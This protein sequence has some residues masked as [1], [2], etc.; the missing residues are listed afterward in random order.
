MSTAPLSIPS[1]DLVCER[2]LRLPC[3]P[4]LLPRLISV[5]V[6]PDS[7]AD[8]VADLIKVDAALAASTLRLA[9]SAFFSANGKADSVTDAVI[10]LGSREL[11]RLAALALVGR[12]ETGAGGRGEPG[13]FC[14][15]ALCTALAAEVLA[16]TSERID[17]QAAYTAGLVC[18]LG[19]L[20]LAH[21]CAPCFPAIRSHCSAHGG[22]WSDAEQAVLGYTH[23]EV[24]ARLLKAWNFPEPLIAAAEFCE[25]PTKAPAE[26]LA[27]LAHLHAAKY[28]ATSFGPGVTE[29]G[30][31]FEL[32]TDFL[33]EWG[34]TP[35]L[36]QESMSIVHERART[37][38]QEKLTHGALVL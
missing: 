22:S 34:F 24:G 8:E 17:P 38:L 15:H 6:A 28:V 29:D 19:K 10:R 16:E 26:S 37:R 3:S 25:H 23:A 13:D 5:L 4:A 36:L 31:L 18:D 1:L 35:E 12:W 27:L 20:A 33:L 2:A 32:N 9:N 7:S 21:A 30:F 11:Y 14:R